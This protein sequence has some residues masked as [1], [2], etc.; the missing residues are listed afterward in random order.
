MEHEPVVMHHGGPE[1]NGL[2]VGDGHFGGSLRLRRPLRSVMH[3]IVSRLRRRTGRTD[4]VHPNADDFAQ[5][6]SVCQCCDIPFISGL[7]LCNVLFLQSSLV[8]HLS[9]RSLDKTDSA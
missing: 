9:L 6:V 8:G 7:F 1:D 5:A 4:D 2:R 3:V